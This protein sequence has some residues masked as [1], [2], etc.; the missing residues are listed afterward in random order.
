MTEGTALIEISIS[1]DLTAGDSSP[2][3]LFLKEAR[4]AERFFDFFTSTIR[5]QNTRFAYSRA[6]ASFFDWLQKKRITEFMAIRPVHV[7]AYIEELQKI[8]SKPTV[9][10]HLAA[11]RMLFD[12][13]V[14]RQC[15]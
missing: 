2:P 9:K 13:L 8:R 4:A 6:V 15:C 3:A 12:W 7:A 10:Q 14:T 5:N 11:I 1:H